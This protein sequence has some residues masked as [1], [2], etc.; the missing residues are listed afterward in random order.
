MLPLFLLLIFGVFE[1]GWFAMV[2]NLVEHAAREGCRLAVVNTDVNNNSNNYD[3]DQLKAVVRKAL[4]GQSLNNITID[5][6]RT[7]ANGDKITG[8]WYQATYQQGIALEITGDYRPIL[9]GLIFTGG[10]RVRSKSVMNS[11]GN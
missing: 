9:A 2:R 6:Y 5:I 3:T 1:F 11:E 4:A 8:N 7:D 10:I